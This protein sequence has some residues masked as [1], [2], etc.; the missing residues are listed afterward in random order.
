MIR[1]YIRY[2]MLSLLSDELQSQMYPYLK[3]LLGREVLR[4]LDWMFLENSGLEAE[5]LR[6][7]ERVKPVEK[8]E[9]EMPQMHVVD[10]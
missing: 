4:E 6:E 5:M 3:K 10:L 8:E 9:E 1:W 7:L 2:N